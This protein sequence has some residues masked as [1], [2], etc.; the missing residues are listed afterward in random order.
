MKKRKVLSL[1]LSICMLFGLM[2][3]P[4]QAAQ[5]S[6]ASETNAAVLEARNGILEVTQVVTVDGQMIGYSRGTGFLIGSDD[7]AQTVIT[8]HHVVNAYPYEEK[9]LRSLVEE[10][11]GVQLAADVKVKSEIR[12]V[13]KRDVY[14]TAQIVNQSEA[15]DFAILKMEQPIYDRQPLQLAD[16]SSVTSTQQV[17]A[18]GFP[19]AVEGA[20]GSSVGE[21]I[22]LDAVYTANDVTVTNGIVS[23]VS[24]NIGTGAPISTIVH[25]ATISGGNSG[26]PLVTT[27]G[28]VVGINTYHIIA[29]NNSAAG[30]NYST[31]INE[32]TDV[33]KALGIEYMEAGISSEP[34][35]EPETTDNTA[36][37]TEAPETTNPKLDNLEKAIKTAKSTS[38][39]NMSADSVAN[40]NTALKEAEAVAEDGSASDEEIDAAIKNL[41]SAVNGLVEEKGINTMLI[42]II[43]AV[44]VVVIVVVVILIVVSSGKKKKKAEA[45]KAA[46]MQR[47]QQQQRQQSMGGG[48]Q[49]GQQPQQ[50]PQQQRQPQPQSRPQQSFNPQPAPFAGNDGSGETSVLN[51]GAGETTVLGG[52]QSIPNAMIVRRKTNERITITKAEFRIGKE[53]R[54]V[55]YCISDNTNISRA[56]ANIVCKNGE[57]YIIDNNA[58]N[59]TSVNGVSVAGGQERK[60]NNNDI[61]KLADEEFQFKM[62]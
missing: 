5:A 13:V 21:S 22:Q 12:V 38:L 34:E 55:D 24:E 35:T 49:W 26:G 54:R 43:A 50:R 17:Y 6:E 7:G 59:G 20:W 56:H 58:T 25:S 44:V 53:R 29:D 15:G 39:E 19:A 14:I 37:E 61:I 1:L 57:F 27:D 23:K 4:M 42:I 33:L 16:S 46:A 9:A 62:L 18:L 31:E 30:Y 36:P 40:F 52:G 45:E 2:L 10:N 8:N 3:L 11:L 28:Y 47:Q 60:L 41:D 32:V 51:D 48:Q